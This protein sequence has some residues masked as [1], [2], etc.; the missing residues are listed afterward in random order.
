MGFASNNDFCRLAASQ[1]IAIGAS[2]TAGTAV[3]AG[4][5]RVRV[6]APGPCFIK[7]GDG[8]PTATTSDVYMPGSWPEYF[9]VTPGQKVAVIQSGSTTGNLSVTEMTA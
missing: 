8:T 7:I 4:A 5:Y 2:S 1:V 9:A 6:A 3:S